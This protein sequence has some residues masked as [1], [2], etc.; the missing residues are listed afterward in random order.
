[1]RASPLVPSPRPSASI[2]DAWWPIRIEA[3]D[4]AAPSLTRRLRVFERQWPWLAFSALAALLTTALVAA[5]DAGVLESYELFPSIT[6][7]YTF[8]GVLLGMSS[9]ALCCVSFFYAL[10][11]RGLQEQL[12]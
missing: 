11:K 9:L 12:P 2:R 6:R 10:R 3:C 4:V 1:M 5:L 7:G 8:S